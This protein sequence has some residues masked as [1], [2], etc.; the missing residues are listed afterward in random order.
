M[1]KGIIHSIVLVIIIALAFF[2]PKTPLAD[3]DLQ[4]SAVLFIVL[5]IFKKFILPKHPNSHLLE[6]I[7]FTLVVLSIINTTGV[8]SSPFF[9]L[10]YFLLF[11]LSLLLEPV[12]SITST[13]ALIIFFL[14]SLPPE[15]NIKNLLPI[16]SLAFLTPFALFMGQQYLE[17]QKAKIKNQKLQ[18]DAYLFLSL[19]LKNH[20]KNI[21]VSVENFLGDHQLEE[22]K[23]NTNKMEHLIEEFE[24]E[25]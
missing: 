25:E 15:Q 16:F 2:L 3:Y 8:V 1:S 7:I 14:N 5:F 24:K 6:S 13:L 17:S 19:M 11:S 18:Q 9:F 23:K 20:L 22:I 10:I 12:I 4:I 21:R